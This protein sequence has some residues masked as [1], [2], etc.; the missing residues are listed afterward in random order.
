MFRDDPLDIIGKGANRSEW[1]FLKDHAVFV[2]EDDAL[3]QCFLDLL[4]NRDDQV[5]ESE[6]IHAP[7][8][9]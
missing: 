5:D 6:R 4:L 3:V 9:P 2:N 1:M 7:S 8:A